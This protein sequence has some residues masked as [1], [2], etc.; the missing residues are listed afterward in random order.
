M[1]LETLRGE[2]TLL[3]EDRGEIQYL[4]GSSSLF[5]T[6]PQ[7]KDMNAILIPFSVSQMRGELEIGTPV[8]FQAAMNFNYELFAINVELDP[9]E[10]KEDFGQPESVEMGTITPSQWA[11]AIL[12]D[13]TAVETHT[14][15]FLLLADANQDGMISEK[16]FNAGFNVIV[17]RHGMP[18]DASG[19]FKSMDANGDQRLDYEE[20][21][22][23][24]T[25]WLQ[26]L[27][28]NQVTANDTALT[29]SYTAAEW[30]QCILKDPRE[31]KKHVQQFL[32][33]WDVDS[34]NMLDRNE[35]EK[36]METVMMKN[37]CYVTQDTLN[38]AIRFSQFDIDS[39]G[40]IDVDELVEA[41][42]CILQSIV[43]PTTTKQS[44]DLAA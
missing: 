34:N 31:M 3:S 16:E 22:A 36:G 43:N 15:E 40:F 17:N 35:F 19:N 27:S 13:T 39:N 37:E 41:Y 5:F 7:F 18:S 6:Q 44:Q 11:A 12:E 23:G 10:S 8:T 38:A 4:S 24:Y 33:K 20:L 2:I 9:C 29:P 42:K 25:A 26:R 21:L 1:D 28:Q 32:M 14:R 30:A